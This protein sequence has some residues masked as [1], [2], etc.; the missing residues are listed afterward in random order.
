MHK[1]IT[2]DDL[3]MADTFHKSDGVLMAQTAV[4]V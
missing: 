1:N 3:K 2:Q 4:G